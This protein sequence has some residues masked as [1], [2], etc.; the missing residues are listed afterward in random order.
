LENAHKK[1]TRSQSEVS[2]GFLAVAAVDGYFLPR[3]LSSPYEEFPS[4]RVIDFVITSASAFSL[5]ARKNWFRG[6]S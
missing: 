3:A 2:G 4:N 6:I 5:A 1:A